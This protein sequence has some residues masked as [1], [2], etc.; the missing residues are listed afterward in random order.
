MINH[1]RAAIPADTTPSADGRR[2][3]FPDHKECPSWTSNKLPR[4]WSSCAAKAITP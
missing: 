3:E 4:V 2:L 1:R